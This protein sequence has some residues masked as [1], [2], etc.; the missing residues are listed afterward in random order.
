[1][2]EAIGLGASVIAFIG[3][4]GQVL[5]GCRYIQ[6]ILND[7]DD[8]ADDFRNLKTEVNL[9][10]L[11]IEGFKRALVDI[12]DSGISQDQTAAVQI[13]LDYADEAVSDVLKF[14][15][16]HKKLGSKWSNIRLAFTKDKCAKYSSRMGRAKSY[17]SAVQAGVLL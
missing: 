17:I 5:Q 6:T 10:E 2:A 1:M 9:F 3:L 7:I 12:A 8:V 15:A 16:K 11:T 14:I 4:T 13:A